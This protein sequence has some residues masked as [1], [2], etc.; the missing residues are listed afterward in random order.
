MIK[1]PAARSFALMFLQMWNI[2]N[3]DPDYDKWLSIP[4]VEEDAKGYVMPYCD[5]PLDNYK[6]G[7]AVD[8]DILNRYCR[9][10]LTRRSLTRSPRLITK[11]S[12]R[13]A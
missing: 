1:G 8:M 5:S 13:Q 12:L 10:S 3:D 4:A 6:A 7:E 9:V 2:G 11:Y